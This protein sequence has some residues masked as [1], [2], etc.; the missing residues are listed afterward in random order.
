MNFYQQ[1]A[2]DI[3]T[4]GHNLLLL[5]R[6]GT[7]KSF[8]LKEIVKRLRNKGKTV[9]ITCSTG[10]ACC[11]YDENACT[12]HQFTGISDGRHGPGEIVDVV[13]NNR[14]YEYVLDNISKVDTV[15]LD[16]CSMISQKLFDTINN[17]CKIK[18]PKRP[19]GG[20]Q[21]IFCGDF[22]QLPPVENLPYG[23]SG[24]YCFESND[25]S[26]CFPHRVVLEENMRQSESK[27][28]QTINGVFDGHVSPDMENFIAKLNR[29]LDNLTSHTVKLFARNDL[30]DDYNRQCLL[31]FPGSMYEY[32]S[33]DSGN[34]SDLSK[35]SV[36]SILWLKIGCPVILMRNLSNQLVNGLQGFVKD[37][38]EGSGP[39]IEFPSI[40]ITRTIPKI[41]FTVYSPRL[42]RDL[43]TRQQYPLKPAF[44][45]TI[46]KAQGMTLE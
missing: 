10:I 16:E 15:I 32:K 37:I 14:K 34:A 6:A 33:E 42:N 23:D 45:L 36:P 38:L 19:F 43:A 12:I 1:R 26:T 27:L 21:M 30:V 24:R 9:Q 22:L 39:V 13:K 20:I 46:H 4:E 17:V 3:S 2:V 5:G 25:F 18:D 41:S 31:E 11:V 28:M 35:I 29:P 40:N 7:G 44:G 8:V